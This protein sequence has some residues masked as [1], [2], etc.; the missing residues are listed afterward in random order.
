MEESKGNRIRLMVSGKELEIDELGV[1]SPTQKQV[2]EL[3]AEVGYL[4]AAIKA[5]ADA[6]VETRLR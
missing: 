1:L 2:E 3:H 5:V 4:A 6:R